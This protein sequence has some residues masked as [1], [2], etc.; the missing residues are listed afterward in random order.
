MKPVDHNWI[1]TPLGQGMLAFA[2][3]VQL[4]VQEVN[5]CAL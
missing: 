4:S 5:F 1:S 2:T 3:E